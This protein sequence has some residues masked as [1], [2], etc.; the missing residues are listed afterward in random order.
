ML[1][2]LGSASSADAQVTIDAAKITC[3]QFTLYRI[4]D[5]QN[6]AI[7]LSGYY[8]GQRNDTTVDTLELA[9]YLQK[10]KDF[11]N[12]NP[13]AKVMQAVEAMLKPK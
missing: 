10:L 9:A 8:H 1:L 5:P 4:T 2:A 13:E 6:V 3:D 7:W 12:L 11:C